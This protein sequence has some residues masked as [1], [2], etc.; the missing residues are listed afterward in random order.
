MIKTIVFDV[1]GVLV[2][3]RW[4]EYLQKDLGIT[5][6]RF[7]A[8][9]RAMMYNP[10]WIELDRNVIPRSE[11]IDGFKQV[12]PSASDDIDLFW[13]DPEYLVV[14]YEDSAEWVRSLHERGYRILLLSNYPESL[15]KLHEPHF[16]FM[17]YVDGKLVS[18]QVQQIKPDEEIYR[19]LFERFAIKPEES[20]F[21]DDTQ[22]NTDAA[23]RLGMHTV[24]VPKGADRVMAKDSLEALLAECGK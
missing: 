16:T 2:D 5:G 6:E 11:V 19:T 12:E 17:P 3:F 24:T 8:V 7:D 9:C 15:W 4:P 10:A 1:G 21:L 13:K 20:V 23:A 14:P 22:A 18:W